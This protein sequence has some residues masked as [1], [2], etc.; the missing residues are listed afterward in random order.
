MEDEPSCI[1][2]C[3]GPPVCYLVD[4]FAVHSQEHGCR[5]CKRIWVYED[6]SEE[7]EEPAKV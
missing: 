3:Q 4:D 1:M 5:W 7:I 6:G 2:V